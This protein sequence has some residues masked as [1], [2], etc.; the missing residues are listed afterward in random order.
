MLGGW[1]QCWATPLSGR[2][3]R[4]VLRVYKSGG[5]QVG[6]GHGL[7]SL[8]S[9]LQ[10]LCRCTL[11]RLSSVP[12]EGVP[13][14][15]L[16]PELLTALRILSREHSG[17]EDLLS[18]NG[19]GVVLQKAGLRGGAPQS[20]FRDKDKLEIDS[21]C[22]ER[23]CASGCGV[24]WC[25][26]GCAVVWCGVLVGVERCGVRGVLVGVG[27]DGVV[28]GGCGV[29]WGGVL[30]GV[31]WCGVLV[32]VVWCDVISCVS[33]WSTQQGLGRADSNTDQSAPCTLQT[34][35][36]SPSLPSPLL[37]PIQLSLRRSSAC[38]TLSSTTNTLQP[39]AGEGV[40]L[41]VEGWGCL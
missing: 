9:S 21:A 25:A 10:L 18:V 1:G 15:P 30:V 26:G 12:A 39:C 13:P 38:S 28:V 27:W 24:G 7:P 35:L 34:N 2:G 20:G 32:G 6:R 33:Q 16:P 17:L 23:V 22:G 37:S 14:T 36:P 40:G 31:V 3:P 8:S 41:L 4:L 5:L 29:G 11:S 19:V